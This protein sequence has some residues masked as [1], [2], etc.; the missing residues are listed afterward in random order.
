MLILGH[1]GITLGSAALLSGALR[2]SRFSQPKEESPQAV[3]DSKNSSIGKSSWL[4]FLWSRVDIRL[5]LIGS[6]LPDIIDKPVGQ[7]FFRETF[8][9]GR[10]FSHT[11]LFLIMVTVAGLYLYR[12]SNREWLLVL[13]FG[14]F[15]HLVLDQMWLAPQTLFWPLLGFTFDR[16]ELADWVPN[17]LQAMLTN[18][19]VYIPELVGAIVLFWF[20]LVLVRR[21]KVLAFIRYGKVR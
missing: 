18:P 13:S 11:L 20:G 3:A 10:I 19:E 4:T 6:L 15:T 12:R 1:T 17:M 8:S 9:N 14:T 21:K 2:R 16:E 7:Y 5:L